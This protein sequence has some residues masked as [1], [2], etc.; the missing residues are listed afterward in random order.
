[1][2]LNFGAEN[3]FK[4]SVVMTTLEVG[5]SFRLQGRKSEHCC[6]CVRRSFLSS[7]CVTTPAS[8]RPTSW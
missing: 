4:A 3:D 1:M 7:L 2:I 5:R 6:L 8:S